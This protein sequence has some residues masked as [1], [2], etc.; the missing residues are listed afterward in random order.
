MDKTYVFGNDGADSGMMGMLSGLLGKNNSMDP[1]LVA[2][3][4][5]GNNNRS[6]FGGEGSWFIWIIL[7]FFM[8]GWG[9]NGGFG[10]N[11]NN[12]LPATLAGDSGRELLM[13]AI[14][15]NSTAINQI[16]AS[17]NSSTQ[18]VQNAICGVNN[19][20]TQIGGQIGMTG[21]QIINAVQMG[22]NQVIQAVSDC[23]CKT[24]NAILT[25]GYENRLADC[26]QTNTLVNTMN[27]NTLQLRDGASANTQAVLSKI[28][29][30]EN[31]YLSDKIDKL[32]E[33]KS[34]LQ[35][36]ININRQTG[37]FAQ[38]INQAVSPVASGVNDLSQRLASIECRQTPT[39][40]V[41]Y[42]PGTPLV[43]YSMPYCANAFGAGVA[44]GETIANGGTW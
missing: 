10:G 3:L 26:Q 29:Q 7:L 17:L 24:Q 34:V 36:E 28:D 23:C 14:Q 38:M 33:E 11:G 16:A 44:A 27:N 20:L 43:N 13:Q 19:T 32:R 40:P 8:G 6:G 21:Q 25:Q 2:A 9:N 22:N 15:G 31:M 18:N 12:A 39:M 30:F 42:M 41:P 5:N 4:M 37:T 1:N 35:N